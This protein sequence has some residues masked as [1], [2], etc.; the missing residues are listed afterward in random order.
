MRLRADVTLLL[1]SIIWGSAFVAQRV[2]G[3]LGSVYLFN[4]VRYLLAAMIVLPF[5]LRAKRTASSPLIIPRDQY[6]WM[7]VAGIIL[8]L[9]SALQQLG[10]VYT[11]AGNAG[12]ITGLYVV[13][14]PIALF[15]VWGE[16]PHWLSMLAVALAGIGAFL[17][18]TGGRFEV[19]KGD[20]IELASAVF[21]TLHVIVLG[22]YA[23]RFES[24]SFSVG[25]LVVCGVLNLGLG[26]FVEKSL[27][28]STSLIGAIVYTAFFSLGLCYTLQIW[29]QRHTPPADAALIL[30]LESVFAVLSGWLLL[31]ERLVAIQI[32][33]CFLIFIAVL[34][35][36]FKEWNLRGRIDHD[37]LVEG[38]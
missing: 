30:S 1:V 9:G 5:A 24:M 31:D 16:R 8:F 27:P 37:H 28:L 36:Q 19:R 10:V 11:T 2:A 4:G 23:S 34:L 12:F 20:V 14:V 15:L 21:W 7:F 38:R 22:K 3:Q 17:L 35:S 29:A 13:L 32:L 6:G 33:G 18:S 25:Q 26:L